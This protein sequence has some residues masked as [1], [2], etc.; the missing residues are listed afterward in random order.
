[1]GSTAML[2]L[3]ISAAVWI[4]MRMGSTVCYDWVGVVEY[5][6]GSFGDEKYESKKA[7]LYKS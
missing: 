2:R 5:D 6:F 4:R 1:M 3:P 7:L